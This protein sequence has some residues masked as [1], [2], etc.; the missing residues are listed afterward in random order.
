MQDRCSNVNCVLKGDYIAG[1]RHREKC[2][3]ASGG[4]EASE[5]LVNSGMKRTCGYFTFSVRPVLRP[6]MKYL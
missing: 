4:V 1:F 3:P 5:E 6:V 2:R